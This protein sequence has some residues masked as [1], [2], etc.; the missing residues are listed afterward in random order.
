MEN[1]TYLRK[2][3][4]PLLGKWSVFILLTL[5]KEEMY[6]AQIERT[7]GSISRKVLTQSLNDLIE[8]NILY[9]RGKAST[10]H[11]TY[12]GLTPLGKRLLPLIHQIKEWIRENKDE[13]EN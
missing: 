1:E 2:L 6:C 9:K 10:G 3:A 5:E 12:Y 4:L 11:K 7:L 13:L 8:I